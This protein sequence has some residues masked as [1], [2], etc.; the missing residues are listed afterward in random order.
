MAKFFYNNIYI[1]NKKFIE[2]NKDDNEGKEKPNHIINGNNIKENIKKNILYENKEIITS[3][4]FNKKAK[5]HHDKNNSEIMND[6]NKEIFEINKKANSN[7]K[8]E[9]RETRI[10]FLRKRLNRSIENDDNEN[11]L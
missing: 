10:N 1:D 11:I 8:N 9:I 4:Q 2:V 5:K 7:N 6:L 3:Y